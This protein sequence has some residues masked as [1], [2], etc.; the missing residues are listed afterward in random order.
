MQLTHGAYLAVIYTV[1]SEKQAGNIVIF[2][3]N[4]DEDED[5]HLRA[6][7]KI[8]SKRK[9][10]QIRRIGVVEGIGSCDKSEN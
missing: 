5:Y 4:Q 9:R 7:K 6:V 1:V 8:F 2:K 10:V 3:I